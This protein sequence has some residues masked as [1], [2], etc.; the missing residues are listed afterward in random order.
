MLMMR[1]DETNVL[2]GLKY[3]NSNATI[4]IVR[5]LDSIIPILAKSKIS[6]LSLVSVA[7]QT[8]LS[9]TVSET[10]KTGFLVTEAH[11]YQDTQCSCIFRNLNAAELCISLRVRVSAM[12]NFYYS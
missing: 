3:W 6:R 9:L 1:L 2:I 7:E 5:Y 10:P 4:L 11:M 12:A 8:G